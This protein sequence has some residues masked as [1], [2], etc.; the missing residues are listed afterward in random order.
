MKLSTILFS[1][2]VVFMLAAKGQSQVVD[3]QLAFKLD[4]SNVT[5]DSTNQ[6]EYD[7]ATKHNVVFNI[8]LSDTIDIKKI[9][10]SLGSSIDGSEF[11]NYSINYNGSFLPRGVKFTRIGNQLI[12]DAGKYASIGVFYASVRLKYS[13]GTYSNVIKQSNAQ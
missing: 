9:E 7:D 3:F 13:D 11:L 6:T 2:G 8:Q 1:L 10:V 5:L 4:P 12:I